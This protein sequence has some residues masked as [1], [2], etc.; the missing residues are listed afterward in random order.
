MCWPSNSVEPLTLEK[1]ELGLEQQ[2]I[3]GVKWGAAAKLSTQVV[4][5]AVPLLVVRLL[6]PADYGL[7]ALCAVVLSTISGLAELGLGAS[8]IQTRTLTDHDVRRVSGALWLLNLSC[9]AVVFLGAPFVAA[10]F[11]QP[12]LEAVLQVSTLQLLRRT[13][14]AMPEALA[15]RMLRFRWLAAVDV[16]AGLVP[17]A[18]TLAL[19]FAGLGVWA[20]RLGNLGGATP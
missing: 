14:A 8:V 6:V 7:M 10:V 13:A 9:A 19:A 11:A 20:L 16:I 18:V 3:V 4:S 15:Y 12:R 5:W 2:A 1:S 17:S